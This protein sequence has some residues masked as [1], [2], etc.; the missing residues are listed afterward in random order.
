MKI[1]SDPVI[2]NFENCKLFSCW[3]VHSHMGT[4]THAAQ[5]RTTRSSPSLR[6]Q[7][8]MCVV[9]VGVL[10]GVVVVVCVVCCVVLWCV[11]DTLKKQCL[12]SKRLRMYIQNVSV[13]AGKTP[14]C[15]R[16]TLLFS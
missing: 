14:T 16:H 4:H 6:A 7:A 15:E 5:P 1:F 8:F 13:C 9:C 2:G 11:R 10:C 12:D 3:V